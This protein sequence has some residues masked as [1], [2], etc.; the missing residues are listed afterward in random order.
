MNKM[1]DIGEV[2]AANSA[3][4]Q[5]QLTLYN[6]DQAYWTVVSLKHKKTLAESFLSLV[7]KL[8]SDV[9]KMIREGV[10]TKADGLKVGVKVNEAEMALTQ[11]DNGLSLAKMYLC[12]LCLLSMSLMLT[13][14]WAMS[15]ILTHPS[16]LPSS[17]PTLVPNCVCCRTL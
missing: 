11:V 17:T 15:L 13:T 2:M 3:E 5:K 10:A 14:M 4:A 9:K 7:K 16:R 8:D 6:I 12:Q 1:A